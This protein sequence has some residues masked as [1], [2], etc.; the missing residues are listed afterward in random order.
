[1]NVFF[2]K[3]VVE[4]LVLVSQFMKDMDASIAVRCKKVYRLPCF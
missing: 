1:V 3:K 4:S 2:V